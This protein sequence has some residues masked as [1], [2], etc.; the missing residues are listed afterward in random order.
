MHEANPGGGG[1]DTPSVAPL[2]S[3]RVPVPTEPRG[4]PADVVFAENVHADAT[5]GD[6]SPAVDFADALVEADA[7]PI[8][9]GL[10]VWL[11]IIAVLG[12]GGILLQQVELA[13]L[14]TLAGAFAA[15]HAAD[16]DASYRPLHLLLSGA[17]V[18]G[19]VL[20]FGGLAVWLATQADP[21]P[22]RPLATGIAGGAAVLS[23]LTVWRPLADG[24]ASAV[25]RTLRP[26][27]VTRLGGRVV[28]MVL[29]FMIPGVAAFPTLID[30]MAERGEPL[31]DTGQ[32]LSS[33]VGLVVLAL[34]G[35]GFMVRRGPRASLERLGL[36][37]PRPSHYLVVALGVAAL[38]LLNVSVE[39]IERTFFPALWQ[40]DDR[41]N[42]MLVSGLGMG[43]MVLLGLSAGVGEELSM[44]GALQPRLG[45]IF[46][47]VVFAS[48]HV[49]YSWLGMA[50]ILL[51]GVLLGVIRD[52]TSTTVAILVHSA[53]DFLAV[54]T[55]RGPGGP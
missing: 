18:A 39:W 25:F 38:F 24:M 47:A 7:P 14:V 32:L 5:W 4:E 1:E 13:L 40:R 34:G 36:R 52:R 6:E 43:G 49:H 2:A 55:T 33:L 26:D 17:M 35:I 30:G 10:R 20:M 19:S 45:L 3:R 50:T 46:T 51:L 42:Q 12:I 41:I 28:L 15:A 16:R 54:V 21:G 23:L 11:G 53:Y 9:L 27:H 37:I 29:L 48:L 31:L 22:L 8:L 44:R